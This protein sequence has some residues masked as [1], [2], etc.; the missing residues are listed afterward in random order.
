MCVVKNEWWQCSYERCPQQHW[1]N[2]V[3][4]A[5]ADLISARTERPNLK[6][7]QCQNGV[8]EC[9]ILVANQDQQFCQEYCK[10]M[11]QHL[12]D[13]RA[14]QERQA[15]DDADYTTTGTSTS[16]G[17]AGYSNSSDTI[18][19]YIPQEPRQPHWRY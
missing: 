7:G 11:Q 2:S 9:N 15:I 8:E 19:R 16:N 3:D 12:E 4:V 17:S 10:R 18:P 6:F 1:L 5:C 14:L 13:N